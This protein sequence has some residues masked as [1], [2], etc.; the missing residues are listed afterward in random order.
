[1]RAV[2][3]TSHILNLALIKQLSLLHTQFEVVYI[4]QAVVTELQLESDVSGNED[5]RQAITEGWIC[6]QSIE[7]TNLVRALL[8]DLDFGE[9][10]A[11]ALALQENI[12]KI[13]VNER[14]GREK[15]KAMG[16]EPVGIIGLLLKAKSAGSISKIGP[17]LQ[18]LQQDAGFW[19]APELQKEILKAAGETD[20]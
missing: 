15:A 4:P 10:E 8:L 11:I 12:T 3:N 16:L 1:M 13:L 18:Q 20:S 2:S 6:I 17:Y 19:I 7:D 5:I 14:D 9:S